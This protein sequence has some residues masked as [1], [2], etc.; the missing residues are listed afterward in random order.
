MIPKPEPFIIQYQ[1]SEFIDFAEERLELGYDY[2]MVGGHEFKTEIIEVADGREQRNV[3]RHLPLGRWQLGQ[4]QIAESE[5]DKLAEASYLLKF[6]EQRKGAKQGFRFKDWA[7]YR[8]TGQILGIGDGVTTKFQ[9]RKA[10]MAGN[11]MTY[12]PIQK[13]VL[14][15]VDLIVDGVNVAVDPDHTWVVNHETGI[16]SNDIPLES[17]SVLSANFEFDIPV[18]FETDEISFNLSYYDPEKNTQL[19]ELGNVFVVEQRLPLALPWVIPE[20]TEITE[21]LNLGI[22]YQTSEK[23]QYSTTKL[24]LNSGFTSRESK[25]EDKRILFDY[26]DRTFDQKELDTLLGYFWNCKG[27]AGEFPLVDKGN[28]FIVRF[29]A[30]KLNIK[31]E[32]TDQNDAL[33]KISGLKLQLKE[34]S[35]FQL[36]PFSIP[37][38]PL[39]IDPQDPALSDTSSAGASFYSGSPGSPGTPNSDSYNIASFIGES[40]SFDITDIPGEVAP[41]TS[42]FVAAM[43]WAQG[44]LQLLV[45]TNSTSSSYRYRLIHYTLDLTN[46]WDFIYQSATSLA[47]RNYTVSASDVNTERIY[48]TDTGTAIFFRANDQSTFGDVGS[49]SGSTLGLL[50]FELTDSG[51]FTTSFVTNSAIAISDWNIP[52]SVHGNQAWLS[53]SGAYQNLGTFD[54]ITYYSTGQTST[55]GFPIPGGLVEREYQYNIWTNSVAEPDQSEIIYHGSDELLKYFTPQGTRPSFYVANGDD[56]SWMIKAFCRLTCETG[57]YGCATGDQI[58]LFQFFLKESYDS[59]PVLVD[60]Q[61]WLSG[62]TGGTSHYL[63]SYNSSQFACDKRGNMLVSAGSRLIY[64]KV[65]TGV[66]INIASQLGFSVNSIRNKPAVTPYGFAVI[67]HSSNLFAGT[68]DLAIVQNQGV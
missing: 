1:E 19:Y 49:Y 53:G 61:K 11:G 27:K 17:G 57:V 67:G 50:K 4:R 18:W 25:R 24:A 2:G 54:G 68:I 8:G 33:F 60:T 31:F 15:T 63:Q 41:N 56:G 45:T 14:G 48:R 9:L 29:N 46:G 22:V 55:P 37:L 30:D 65:G 10:Y 12:R 44:T 62:S 42:Y 23:F 13:P 6:H 52:N 40:V 64:Y 32:A 35:I 3:L 47:L 66:G 20:Q 38:E 51:S 21:E 36:P 59:K 26:G 16:V 58:N 39:L 5:L 43:F 28:R 7:D 34:Q